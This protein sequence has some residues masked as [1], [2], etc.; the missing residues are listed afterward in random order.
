MRQRCSAVRALAVLVLWLCALTAY[1]P[2]VVA[3]VSITG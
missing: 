1:A 3:Q 2:A